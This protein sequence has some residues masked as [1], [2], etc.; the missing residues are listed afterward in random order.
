MNNF[1]IEFFDKVKYMF[2]NK[3]VCSIYNAKKNVKGDIK[4]ISIVKMQS[5]RTGV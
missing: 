2:Y 3:N 5:K 4:C 1:I